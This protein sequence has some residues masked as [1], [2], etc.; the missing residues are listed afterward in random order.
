MIW[1]L[2]RV[3]TA[4]IHQDIVIITVRWLK[5]MPKF[6][7]QIYSRVLRKWLRGQFVT[8]LEIVGINGSKTKENNIGAD[9]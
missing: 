8:I 2:A 7:S 1:R 5:F 4:K 6:V 3:I 9:R